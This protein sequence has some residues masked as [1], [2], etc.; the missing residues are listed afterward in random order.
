MP[1]HD[2]RLLRACNTKLGEKM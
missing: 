1:R 2:C